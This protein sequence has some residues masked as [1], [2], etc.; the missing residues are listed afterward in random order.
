MTYQ[1][2]IARR[3]RF[4]TDILLFQSDRG[5][6]VVP[7]CRNSMKRADISIRSETGIPLALVVLLGMLSGCDNKANVT[8]NRRRFDSIIANRDTTTARIRHEQ[9][10]MIAILDGRNALPS[11]GAPAPSVTLGAN[12]VTPTLVAPTAR[13]A[14]PSA[15][16]PASLPPAESPVAPEVALPPANS[17]T[18]LVS[19]ATS[20]RNLHALA[21]GDSIAN[22]RAQ[23]TMGL[24]KGTNS[25]TDTVRGI[26]EMRGAARAARATLRT[27]GGHKIISL[28][29]IASD[30]LANLA[31]A[32]V[33]V[34]GI[35]ISALDLVVSSYAVRTVQGVP[36]ID[37][38]LRSAGKTWSVELS[39]KSGVQRLSGVPKELQLAENSRVW[40][41]LAP[42]TSTPKL[43]GV[44]SS[45]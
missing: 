31:G 18:P 2:N 35:K 10:S 25:A 38:K 11:P 24:V 33:M 28:S 12:S 21:M 17:K 39:D 41:V 13:R 8:A 44:I 5:N 37:G 40:I 32:E 9:D 23:R 26:I 16:L 30:G 29:G 20:A 4:G 45:R 43:F 34:R 36:A 22:A 27:D 15:P 7:L 14:S 1:R 3:W 19:H 42:N 6:V